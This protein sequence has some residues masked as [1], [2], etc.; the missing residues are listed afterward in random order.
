MCGGESV[1]IY[2]N[3]PSPCCCPLTRVPRCVAVPSFV[4]LF[5]FLSL[6]SLFFLFPLSRVAHTFAVVDWT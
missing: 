6:F 2:K 1:F 4:P 5:F 3:P